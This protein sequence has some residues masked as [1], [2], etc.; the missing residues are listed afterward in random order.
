VVEWTKAALLGMFQLPFELL[1]LLMFGLLTDMLLKING[2]A[3]LPQTR[4]PTSVLLSFPS[5]RVIASVR[6]LFYLV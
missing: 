2:V 3:S 4:T 1:G 6:S 5:T